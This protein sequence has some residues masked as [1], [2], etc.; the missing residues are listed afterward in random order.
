[1][2][3]GACAILTE[4]FSGFLSVSLVTG[5]TLGG[6]GFDSRQGQEIF[7]FSTSS[8]PSLRLTQPLIHWVPVALSP[9]V[10]RPVRK[11]DHSPPSSA[12]IKYGGVIPPLPNKL[13]N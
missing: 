2:S 9:L 10:K 8:R 12:E 13:I 7:L 11:A 5:Y 3:V 6:H 4:G 1:M